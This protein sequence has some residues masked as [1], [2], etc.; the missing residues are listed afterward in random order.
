MAFTLKSFQQILSGMITKFKSKSGV[1]DFNP[2]SVISTILEA[3]SS[4]DFQAYYQMLKI[5]RNYNLDTTEGEDLD[6]RAIEIMG[7]E[8]GRKEAEKATGLI[9][10]TDSSF[11]KISTRIYSGFAGPVKNQN[12][13]YVDDA[14]AFPTTGNIV[15]GRNTANVET[16]GYSNITNFIN[17]YKIDLTSNLSND[18]GTD[19]TVIYS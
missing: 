15:I 9:T 13:I 11:S 2:G 7:P 4:E 10:I 17:Y 18:H 8:N 12:F 3:A 6:N 14:S 1:T 16:I 5:I 19:E